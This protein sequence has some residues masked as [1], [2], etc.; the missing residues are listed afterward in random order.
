MAILT[1]AALTAYR[2]FTKRRVKYA[3]YYAG[4]VWPKV[5]VLDFRTTADG[6]VEIAVPMDAQDAGNTTI[7]QVQLYD[8]E[9]QLWAN[10]TVNL[11]LNSVAEGFTYVIRLKIEEKEESS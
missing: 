10:K 7:T 8:A 11:S 3:R 1:A 4:S 9:G 6:I 2:E 5:T